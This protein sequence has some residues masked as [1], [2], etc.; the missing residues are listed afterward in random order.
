MS[1]PLATRLR[2]MVVTDP[3]CAGR[4]LVDVVRAAL[5]GGAPCIQLRLKEGSSREMLEAARRLLEETRA[6]G[7]LLLV[8]DRVDVAIAAGAEGAHLGDDD[9]PVEQ[10][11]RIVPA[12]FVIGRSVDGAEGARAAESAGADYLG[13]GPVLATPSKRDAGAAIGEAGVAAV[14]SAS[15]LPIVAI[16]GIDAHNAAGVA[17]AGADGVAVI[18]AV[19][20]APDPAAA[21][22]AL[23][24][25]VERGV[26]GR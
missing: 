3:E 13:V 7:A 1:G 19:M 25:A 22:R 26:A 24:A 18:R 14:H 8:N 21:S 4:E 17:R 11:R 15:A 23:L 5:R 6:A 16:G 10:A 9:L 20:Q 2:L 12:G